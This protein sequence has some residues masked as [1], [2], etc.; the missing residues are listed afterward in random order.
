MIEQP[1][2]VIQEIENNWAAR[3]LLVVGDYDV[4]SVVG[5]TEVQSWGGQVRI[6][7]L[8]EGC[9]TTRLIARGADN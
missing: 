5:A 3:R 4:D 7:P 9:S 8:F 6:V 1:S 2:Q